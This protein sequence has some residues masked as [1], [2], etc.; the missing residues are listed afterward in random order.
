MCLEIQ[1]TPATNLYCRGQ[2]NI[3]LLQLSVQVTIKV[4]PDIQIVAMEITF[5]Y[6]SVML[7]LN[8]N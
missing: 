7:V 8:T 1:G 3:T 2:H 6:E 4:N 5:S